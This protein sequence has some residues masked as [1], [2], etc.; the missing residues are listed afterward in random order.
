MA[1]HRLEVLP[2][3]DA[4]ARRGAE[5]IAEAARAAVAADGGFDMAA[6]GGRTPWAMYGQLEDQEMP[7]SETRIFQTDERIA[8]AGSSERNLSHLIAALSLGVQGS[9]KPMP[10]TDDNAE[11]AADE[12][13]SGLPHAL[14]L[15]HLGLGPDGHTASLVPG[16]PVLEVTDRKVA[17]TGGE[18]QGHPRMTLTYPAI[19]AAKRILFLVTGAEKR[20]PLQKLLAGDHSIPAGRV[21]NDQIV[22]VADEAAADS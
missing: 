22:V 16:D 7:W 21:D 5:L 10:V 8:P 14:D 11:A 19:D 13:A 17:M 2:D 6:S 4:V 9:L 3:A 1:E 12:Y 18:Y 15:V 20:D